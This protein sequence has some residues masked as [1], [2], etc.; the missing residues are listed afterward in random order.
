MQL[1]KATQS[2]LPRI[3]QLVRARLAEKRS[4]TWGY[5]AHPGLD[6]FHWSRLKT[7]CSKPSSPIWLCCEGDDPVLLF[8]LQQNDFHSRVFRNA[9]GRVSPF[10]L[11]QP[12]LDTAMPAL[13]ELRRKAES[14]KIDLLSLRIS[15]V[16]H[17]EN[18]ALS[19]ARWSHVGCSVKL[20]LNREK[21]T[22][23]CIDK[24]IPTSYSNALSAANESCILREA[25]NS[26]TAV[27]GNLIRRTHRHSHFFNDPYFEHYARDGLF[28][29]WIENS[30]QGGMD[31]VLVAEERGTPV[32]FASCLLSRGLTPF[33]DHDVGVLDFVAVDP[34][35]QGRGIG[36]R[37]LHAA[38]AWLFERVPF[39]ELR[40]MIDNVGALSLYTKLGLAVLSGDHHYHYWVNERTA[41]T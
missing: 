38:F 36:S 16:D 23:Y 18:F 34:S 31:L 7:L 12:S 27:L 30:V 17:V 25:Q 9:V 21:W 4:E 26:D 20:G 15:T 13:D 37:L 5:Y 2:D 39:L 40:T 29:A 33:I 10:Y 11:L 35:V 22:K 24:G 32:G 28:P 1:Q 19:T 6:D 3:E 41:P 14:L 8:A